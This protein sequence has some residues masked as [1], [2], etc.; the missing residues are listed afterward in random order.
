MCISAVFV[1]VILHTAEL[2]PTTVRSSAIGTSSTMAHIG[3]IS[4]PY[5]VD[6]LGSLVWYI[7]T[8]ICGAA[9][10]VAGLLVLGLPETEHVELN[11]TV[12]EETTRDI[13]SV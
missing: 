12:E 11:D 6:G 8:T 10:V 5:I 13:K 9:S 7:P 1:V 4:A 2:F 3:S